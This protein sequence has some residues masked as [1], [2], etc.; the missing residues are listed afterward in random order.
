MSEHNFRLLSFIFVTRCDDFLK[1]RHLYGDLNLAISNLCRVSV[2]PH[3]RHIKTLLF[4]G[5]IQLL[6]LRSWQ[7]VFS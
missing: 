2:T 3:V 4:A 6:A 7:V 5:F 1:V